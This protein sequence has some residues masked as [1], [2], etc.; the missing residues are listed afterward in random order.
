MW[1]DPA[2]S[3]ET[4]ASDSVAD[5]ASAGRP[6]MAYSSSE[7]WILTACGVPEPQARAATGPPIRMWLARTRSA[8]PP[9]AAATAPALAST[10]RSS[11]AAVMSA[12]WRASMPS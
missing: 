1:P 9:C 5:A 12:T 2:K 8:P 4:P 11:S 3:A 10:K 7:P 6:R